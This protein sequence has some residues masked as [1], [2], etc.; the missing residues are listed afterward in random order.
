MCPSG[1]RV[2]TKATTVAAHAAEKESHNSPNPRKN[3]KGKNRTVWGFVSKPTV[4]KVRYQALV[5]DAVFYAEA[6]E[7]TNWEVRFPLESVGTQIMAVFID[8]YGNDA[9]E[10]IPGTTF[11]IGKARTAAQSAKKRQ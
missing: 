11:G 3:R 9:R 1:G 5:F 6:I 2:T 7:N 8:I 4:K 10:V